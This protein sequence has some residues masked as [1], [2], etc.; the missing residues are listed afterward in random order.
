MLHGKKVVVVLPAYKAER[1]LEKTYGEIPRDVVDEVLLV[2]DASG[3]A[4]VAVARRLGID[5]FVHEQ[6][7]GY[8]GNQK[9]AY[10]EGLPKNAAIAV[11]IQ[12]YHLDDPPPTPRLSRVLASLD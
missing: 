10:T 9:T 5:T 4:T 8:G 6:N 3:D 1:T 11:I 7:L 2:D 12:S